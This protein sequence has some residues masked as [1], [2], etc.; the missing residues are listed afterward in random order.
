MTEHPDEGSIALAMAL[1]AK[2]AAHTSVSSSA[3][4]LPVK[5]EDVNRVLILVRLNWKKKKNSKGSVFKANKTSLD[6][7]SVY[8]SHLFGGSSLFILLI[9]PSQQH[10]K[11]C[12]LHLG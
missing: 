2:E 11:T 7:F 4:P 12:F 8:T 10:S 9:Y 1:P 6:R 3:E 5:T